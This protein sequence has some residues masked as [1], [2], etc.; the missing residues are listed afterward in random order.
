V[1]LDVQRG[2]PATGLPTKVE[3]GDLL[4][5][6][7]GM[8]GDAPKVVMAPSTIEECFSMIITARKLA[9]SFSTVVIVL[10]DANLGTGQCPFPYPELS[11]DW[12]SPPVDQSPWNK[13]VRPYEWDP[14][15]GL[16]KR[17]VSRSDPSP[18]NAT[19][20]SSSPVW[21]TTRRAASPTIRRAISGA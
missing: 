17:P 13:D 7:F 6:M 5:S 12:L 19:A 10:S 3:Q 11:E 2:G 16:S 15:T 20:C 4:S 1:V 9:E 21:H 18:A 8:P 14:E